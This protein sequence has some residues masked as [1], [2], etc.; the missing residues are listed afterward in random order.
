MKVDLDEETL[1]SVATMTG[2][3]Y[4]RATDNQKL[5]AIYQEIDQLER[6]KIEVTAY[7]KYT[8]LFPSWLMAGFL[9][10]AVELLLSHGVLR[11][12]P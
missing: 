2:G 1:E 8:E 12:V 3:L 7:K 6:T 9:L 4:F 10:L 5:Q 11:K